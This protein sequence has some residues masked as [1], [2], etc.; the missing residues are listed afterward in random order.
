MVAA[1]RGRWLQ[2]AKHT[3]RRVACRAITDDGTSPVDLWVL[4]AGTSQFPAAGALCPAGYT[5]QP[6][7]SFEENQL[8]LNTLRLEGAGSAW[9]G[10]S[11]HAA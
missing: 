6:P 5:F 4:P 8:L 3:Q 11:T 1:S 10:A 9:L 7:R 2:A